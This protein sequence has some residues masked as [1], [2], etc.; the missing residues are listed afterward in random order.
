MCIVASHNAVRGGRPGRRGLGACRS[1]R[2]RGS[3]G[4][5]PPRADLRLPGRGRIRTRGHHGQDARATCAAGRSTSSSIVSRIRGGLTLGATASKTRR[6]HPA[7]ASDHG[8]ED[9]T[10]P[11]DATPQARGCYRTEATRAG[12]KPGPAIDMPAGVA[13][14][15]LVAWAVS[16]AGR[17][18]SPPPAAACRRAYDQ[19][20][21]ASRHPGR[22][23]RLRRTAVPIRR[24]LRRTA[25]PI[26]R[27][28]RRTAVPIRRSRITRPQARRPACRTT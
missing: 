21:N 1:G 5:A 13:E 19:P 10:V 7:A 3:R 8:L 22:R 23:R 24:R 11:P 16:L 25:V 18:A 17:K 28:L 12:Y 14:G 20:W 27:R 15:T 4:S 26:R 2:T 6:W 9:E